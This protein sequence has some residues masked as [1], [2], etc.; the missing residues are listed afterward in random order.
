MDPVTIAIVGTL[1][2]GVL[3]K[4]AETVF[5]KKRNKEVSAKEVLAELETPKAPDW[6]DDDYV[7][8]VHARRIRK[9]R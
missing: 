6:S 8:D 4:G 3:I 1:L 5:K 2:G 9:T 7:R